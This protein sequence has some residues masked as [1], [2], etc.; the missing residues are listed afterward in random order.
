MSLRLATPA[1][2]VE[3]QRFTDS[4]SATVVPDSTIMIDRD[5]RSLSLS[6]GLRGSGSLRL[7]GHRGRRGHSVNDSDGPPATSE[8][9]PKLEVT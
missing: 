3:V 1:D 5:A 4:G 9:H 6:H 7:A 2:S 8:W